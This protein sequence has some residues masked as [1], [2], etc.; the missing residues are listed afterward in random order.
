MKAIRTLLTCFFTIVL[1]GLGA[2]GP[3]FAEKQGKPDKAV[4]STVNINKAD[5]QE[6]TVALSNIGEKKAQAIVKYREEHGLFTS[7]EQ[8]LNI[9]GI[10]ETTLK[11]NE[12]LISL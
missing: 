8:L 2:V 6:L 5:V 7:K 4:V 1:L 11:K 9:K 12:A 10:G 3:T